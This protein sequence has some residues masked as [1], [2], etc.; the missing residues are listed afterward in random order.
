MRSLSLVLGTI[1]VVGTSYYLDEDISLVSF[2]LSS[3][4]V[5]SPWG[6]LACDSKSLTD[7]RRGTAIATMVALT[8]AMWW[9]VL[10]SDS[11]TAALGILFLTAYQ[12]AA[13]GATCL[14][15]SLWKGADR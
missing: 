2:L 10:T 7:Q 6:F 4:Y 8:G 14:G 15:A 13:I 3:A 1:A 11:S 5:F 9:S 12:W